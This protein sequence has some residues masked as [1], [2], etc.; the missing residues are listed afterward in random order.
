MEVEILGKVELLFGMT[1]NGKIG[2]FGQ[3]KK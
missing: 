2:K 1:N 3:N